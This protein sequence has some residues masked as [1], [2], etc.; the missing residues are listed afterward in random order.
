MLIPQF[1]LRWLL[2]TT[3]LVALVCAMVAWGLAGHRWALAASIG[4]GALVVLMLVYALVFAAVWGLS[5]VV[6]RGAKPGQSPF[7]PSSRS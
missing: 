4:L 7:Q 2:G 1:S 3:T 5:L 6:S